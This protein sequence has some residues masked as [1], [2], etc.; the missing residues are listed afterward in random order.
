MNCEKIF[1]VGVILH[2]FSWCKTQKAHLKIKNKKNPQNTRFR[3]KEKTN[4]YFR[5]L[6]C[7]F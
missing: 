5:T 4:L 2:S 6:K 1:G 7:V 3:K